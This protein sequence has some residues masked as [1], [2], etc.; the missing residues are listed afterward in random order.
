LMR[1]AFASKTYFPGNDVNG[2]P[3]LCLP[4]IP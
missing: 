1:D 3:G 4:G 2:F